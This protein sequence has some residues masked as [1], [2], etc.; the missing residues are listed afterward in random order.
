LAKDTVS[1]KFICPK[2]GGTTLELPDNYTD[3]STAKC[4]GCG[5]DFGAYGK[6]KARAVEAVK[7]QVVTDFKKAFKGIKLR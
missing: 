4:K 5:A 3:A 1:V 6:I 2:C 7:K